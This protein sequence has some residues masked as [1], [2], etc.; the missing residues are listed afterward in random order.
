MLPAFRF[1][2]DDGLI[3]IFHK[4]IPGRK[5]YSVYNKLLHA[6]Y[7]KRISENFIYWN[8]DHILLRHLSVSD[9]KYWHNGLLSLRLGSIFNRELLKTQNTLAEFPNALNFD[10]HAPMIVN[11]TSFINT[12]KH[13]SVELC[14]KTTYC[15]D[16]NVSKLE[17]MQDLKIKDKFSEIELNDRL[18]FSTSDMIA[19]PLINYLE[20]K[21]PN[22]SK[23]EL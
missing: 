1:N 7:D 19:Q 5:E 15:A 17:F 20:T 22:K 2:D 14:L 12:F 18:F 16:N 10:I 21:F 9:F 23:F 13:R 4:D 8:D 6:C 3:D 11:K